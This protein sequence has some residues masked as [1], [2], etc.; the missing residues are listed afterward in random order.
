MFNSAHT[1]TMV[2][3]NSSSLGLENKNALF[4]LDLGSNDNFAS[5][6][7]AHALQ[8]QANQIGVPTVADSAFMGAE[9]HM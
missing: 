5:L 7:M 3:D 2:H 1:K 6:E 8:L 9:A 4:L